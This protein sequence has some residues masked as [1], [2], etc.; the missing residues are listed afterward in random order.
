MAFVQQEPVLFN[1]TILDNIAYG[2]NGASKAQCVAAA[3]AS[4]ADGFIMSFPLGYGTEVGDRGGQ[5]SGGQKQRIAI[6]RSIVRDPAVLLLDEATSALDMESE[7]VVQRALDK[8]IRTS[9]CTTIVVAHRLATVQNA[10]QIV[11]IANGVAREQG[12]PCQLAQLPDGLYARMLQVQ[13]EAF[14]PEHNGTAVHDVEAT[15]TA[16]NGKM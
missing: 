5:L 9:A 12:A 16:K 6:A 7:K 3:K 8:V 4:N 10:S 13:R 11:V 15:V 14:R 1:G 2:R